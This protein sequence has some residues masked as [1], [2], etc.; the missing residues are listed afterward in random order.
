MI[1]DITT[2]QTLVADSQAAQIPGLTKRDLAVTPIANMSFAIVG[3]RRCGKTFRTYQYMQELSEKGVPRNNICRVQFN[4]HRLRKLTAEELGI[5]DQAYFSMFPEKRG[6]E[7]VYFIFDEIHRIEGW[8]DYILYLLEQ[9]KCSVLITGSTSKLL[10][11]QIASALRGKNF[12]REL[13]P[14]SFSE[15]ARHYKIEPDTVSSQG[16]AQLLNLL[17]RYIQQGGFPGLLDLES[18]LHHDLLTS[19]WD[20]MILRDIIEAH[21]D[22]NINIVSFTR[23]LYALL[24]R[25]SCPVTINRIATN[26]RQE[27]VKF[28]TETL[29]KYLHYLQEAYLLFPVEF[30]SSSEKVRGQNYR[31]LYAVDWALADAVVPTEG[32]HP[33]RQF[34]NMIYLELR[35]RGYGVSYYRTRQGYEVDFVV[36]DR[37]NSEK[38]RSLFQVCYA[39]SNPDV[40]ERELRALSK[41]A[42]HLDVE[43]CQVITMNS[44]ETLEYDGIEIRIQP[45]WR[46]LLGAM[47]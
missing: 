10:T 14:F 3:A 25:T 23:F 22:D 7:D 37:K 19:Y 17:Q 4:D 38:A 29:Y 36:T 12:S 2:I 31:K 43:S 28:S 24:A 33:T 8:E 40:R 46:W 39:L 5:I 13:T 15:F 20:T 9:P 21:P 11:G 35:R 45:A 34:E 18:H 27:G 16:Q 6:S 32:V 42:R 44:Q 47:L 41:A 30:F 1:M 26:L